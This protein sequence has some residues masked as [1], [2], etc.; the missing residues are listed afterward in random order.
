MGVSAGVGDLVQLQFPVF[1]VDGITVLTGLTDSDFDKLLALD[2]S[3][4]G[5]AVTVNEIGSGL[6]EAEFTPPSAGLW[7][8]R[9]ITP[10][11]DVYVQYV[12]AGPPAAGILG[13]IADAVWGEALP[14]AFPSDS[15]G[16]RLTRVT[17]ASEIVRDA[18]IAADLS[19]GAGST[20]SSLETGATQVDGFYDGLVVVVKSSSGTVARRID[21]Y[22][23]ADGTFNLADELPFTPSSGDRVIVLGLL[24]ELAVSGSASSAVQIAEIHRILGLDPEAPLCVSKTSQEAGNITLK[25]S[26]VGKAVKVRRES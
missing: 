26:E 1:D 10:V 14:G 21:S 16:D 24:G 4:S 5:V 17:A 2:D 9:I 18:L 20:V 8:V 3:I 12:E 7:F 25:Q 15:A 6:Y 23:Q 19:A 13:S 22:E 11:D